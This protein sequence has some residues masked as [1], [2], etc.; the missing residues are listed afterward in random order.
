ME[1]IIEDWLG[2]ELREFSDELMS[3]FLGSASNVM[4]P[5]KSFDMVLNAT[6]FTTLCQYLYVIC[7]LL[8]CLKMLKKGFMV[9]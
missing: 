1:G 9:Y 6:L 5:E 3:L 7:G 8:L 4:Y 2:S